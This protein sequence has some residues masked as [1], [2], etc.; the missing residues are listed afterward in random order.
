MA[1]EI[2]DILPFDIKQKILSFLDPVDIIHAGTINKHFYSTSK[3][4]DVSPQQ[5]Q[6]KKITEQIIFYF[7]FILFSFRLHP[8]ANSATWYFGAHTFFFFNTYYE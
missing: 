3:T 2:L 5:Q 7:I 1:G 4:D 6:Q 8:H